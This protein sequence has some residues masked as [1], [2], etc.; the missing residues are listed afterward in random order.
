MFLLEQ[1]R[2]DIRLLTPMVL[3]F[4]PSFKGDA[5]DGPRAD[6]ARVERGHRFDAVLHAHGIPRAR[7][8]A[9]ARF[10]R[11]VASESSICKKIITK[12]YFTMQ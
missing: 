9:Q 10:A 11:A 6:G 7:A 2:Q 1:V 5:V 8:S 3:G 4:T 12:F